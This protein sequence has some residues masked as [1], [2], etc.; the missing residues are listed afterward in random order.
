MNNYLHAP[1]NTICTQECLSNRIE[2]TIVM[3]NQKLPRY[4]PLVTVYYVLLCNM[5]YIAY[6]TLDISIL[7]KY[8]RGYTKS[9]Y[10]IIIIG[11]N[12]IIIGRNLNRDKT[13]FE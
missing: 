6:T 4:V 13:E 7:I 1:N 3:L 12:L 11:R 9:D 10:K 2:V 5:L 8:Q